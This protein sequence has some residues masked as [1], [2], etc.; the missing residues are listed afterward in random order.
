MPVVT[1]AVLADAQVLWDFHRIDDPLQ[2]VDIAI[3]LGSHDP[4]VPVY[5]AELY[6][7]G[8]FPLIVFTGANAPTT[9]DTFPRGEAVHY[10]E[11]AI[12]H[13]VPASAIL[14]ETR[15]THTGENIDFTC[16]LLDE[17]G[18][19]V[20]SALLLSRPYQQRRA[21]STA[22]ARWPDIDLSCSAAHTPMTEYLAKIGTER[23]INMLV[24]DTQRL[25]HYAHTDEHIPTHVQRAYQR[26]ITAGYT[27]RLLRSS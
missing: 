12:E 26:L 10:R 16:A 3:G 22:I 19:T 21:R 13:G 8:L 14:L 23:V 20:H 18:I 24:G 25:T 11:I 9:I 1:D 7:Q 4:G 15:A 17:H 2:P 6:H 27:T 5:A